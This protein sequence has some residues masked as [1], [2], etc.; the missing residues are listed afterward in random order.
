MPIFPLNRAIQIPS[1]GL[2]YFLFEIFSWCDFFLFSLAFFFPLE[3]GTDCCDEDTKLPLLKELRTL[4]GRIEP[5]TILPPLSNQRPPFNL[6][7]SL[8]FLLRIL[9]LDREIT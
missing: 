4:A 8:F 9:I 6:L 7:V 2:V 1:L 3:R 5:I